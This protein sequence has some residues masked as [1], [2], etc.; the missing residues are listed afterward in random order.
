[1]GLRV[2]LRM[3]FW[4]LQF[5]WIQIG[6]LVATGAIGANELQRMN[7]ILGLLTQRGRACRRGG[8]PA[9]FAFLGRGRVIVSDADNSRLRGCPGRAIELMK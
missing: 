3:E 1:M 2:K 9:T 7:G 8:F 5:Q 6:N 4:R